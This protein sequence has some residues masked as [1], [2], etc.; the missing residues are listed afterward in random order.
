MAVP[1]LAPQSSDL[2][3]APL[4]TRFLDYPQPPYVPGYERPETVWVS[5]PSGKVEAGPSDA[6]IYVIVPEERKAPY[7][8]PSL[9]PF[10][11][12]RKPP[13]RSGPDGHFDHLIPGTPDFVAAQAYAC[14]RRVLDICESYHGRSI[15]WFFEPA[16]H[17]LEIIPRLQWDNA[18]SGFG[19]LELGED[20]MLQDGF[21]L[22][23]NFDA[24]AHE[25]GHLVLLS[26][27]GTPR[28]PVPP[29]DFFTYHECAADFVSLLALL[30][31]DTALDRI[32]R[33]TKGNLLL[34][35]ELDRFA[36]L[37]VEKQVRTFNHSLKMRDVGSEVHDRA[38]P[39]MGALFDTLIEIY[40]ILLV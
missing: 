10:T 29:A 21:P 6:Q 28:A 24:V 3:G 4:G 11:G 18:H 34:M 5:T 31:F 36:E 2:W 8:F 40:Q 37:S 13:V 12:R 14:V 35:N 30:H 20:D 26:A 7:G 1:D 15:R 33:R 16:R 23:L 32:L 9:P 25:T 19:Y 22:A 17:R 27:L 39:F 38:R